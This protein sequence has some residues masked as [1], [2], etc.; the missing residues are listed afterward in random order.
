MLL[1]F[2]LDVLQPA[3][4][5]DIPPQ[6][7]PT[8]RLIVTILTL[9]GALSPLVLARIQNKKNPSNGPTPLTPASDTPRLD[10]GQQYLERF[11]KSLED[12]VI[13][14]ESRAD[15]LDRRCQ[16]LLEDRA[17]IK[18]ELK[19]VRAD[20]TELRDEVHLLRGRLMGHG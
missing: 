19:A 1:V 20:N 15:E 14:A 16:A 11:V 12:R 13:H 8:G 9:L 17:T 7:D 6:T 10:V 18:A 3:P 5:L 2:L 4:G